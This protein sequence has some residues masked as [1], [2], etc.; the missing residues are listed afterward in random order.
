MPA[1]TKRDRPIHIEFVSNKSASPL[2]GLPA[3]EALAQEFGLWKKIKA[4]TSLDPRSRKGRGYGPDLIISQLIYSVGTGGDSLADAEKLKSDPLAKRLAG[5]Q[6][7]ADETTLGEWLRAQSP[8]SVQ[9]IGEI[10]REFILWVMQRAT[11]GRWLHNGQREVFFDDTELEVSG[12]TFEGARLNYEGQLALSWQVMWV[13]PF[14]AAQS[15]GA[16]PEPS[17][18]L[19]ALLKTTRPLWEGASAYFYADSASSAVKYLEPINAEGWPWS[20]SYNKWTTALERQAQSWPEEQWTDA[21]VLEWKNGEKLLEHYT[22]IKHQPE[23]AAQPFLFAVVRSKGEKELFWRYAFVAC[24]DERKGSPKAVFE[25]HHLK[26]H[27]EQ[28]FSEV[29]TGLDLHH[30]PCA[31]LIANQMYYAVAALAYNLLI[32]LKL[33]H[34]PE[35][36]QQCRVKTL[37][38]EIMI[39]PGR[40]VTHARRLVARIYVAPEW[41]DWWRVV[42][43]QMSQRA[44]AS[45]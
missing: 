14:L 13:G 21:T 8:E 45:G 31:E 11:P 30:P 35:E 26:G 19:L 32:A 43:Q 3:I 5:V 41:L 40:F 10:T 17:S 20:V 27:K 38:R 15:L 2:G 7:F 29:L 42:Y 24:E 37:I 4:A 39:L 28:L 16:H 33:L 34:L 12:K 23:S 9:A 22:W 6:S 1:I 36:R 25:R 44:A 18:Q